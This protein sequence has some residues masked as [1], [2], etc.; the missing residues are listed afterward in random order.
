MFVFPSRP[1]D[2]P[3]ADRGCGYCYSIGVHVYAGGGWLLPLSLPDG[4]R[5]EEPIYT[6]KAYTRWQFNYFIFQ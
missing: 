6:G 5:T 3:A 4:E 2:W 1:F